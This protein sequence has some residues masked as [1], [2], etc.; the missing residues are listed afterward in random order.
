MTASETFLLPNE[1]TLV[2]A[3]S[4]QSA[5]CWRSTLRHGDWTLVKEFQDEDATLKERDIGSDRPGR[6]FDS[7]GSGRHA[8]APPTQARDQEK[9]RF[10]KRIADYLNGA[11][12]AGDAEHLVILA[13]PRCLGLLRNALSNQAKHAVVH[14]ASKNLARLDATDIRKYFQ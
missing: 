2:V 4:A 7:R 14:E 9:Q 1:P 6:T 10:A 11:I 5:R 8:M 13:D 12:S 3:C